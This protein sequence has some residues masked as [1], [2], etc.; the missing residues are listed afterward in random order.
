MRVPILKS[1]LGLLTI[2]TVIAVSSF[3]QSVPAATQQLQISM[4]GTATPVLTGFQT[5]AN[6]DVGVGADIIFVGL[7]RVKAGIEIRGSYPLA[8]GDLTRQ[9][10]F[11]TGPVIQYPLGR[12][13]PY[14]DILFG[15]GAIDYLDGGYVSGG[16][17]YIKSSTFVYSPGIG[18]DYGITHH[19]SI[20]ADFQYQHWNVPVVLSGVIHT[21]MVSLGAR[22]M[23]DFNPH[24]NRNR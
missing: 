16:L 15:R 6:L 2:N 1:T 7:Q 11:V 19:M 18:V 24:H 14:A 13:C 9:K 12:L 3:A 8:D 23:F 22:Y 17:D 10:S 20:K 5:S 4:F 21:T